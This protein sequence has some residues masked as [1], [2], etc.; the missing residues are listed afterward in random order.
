[1][2]R[3]PLLRDRSF[4]RQLLDTW[5]GNQLLAELGGL[6]TSADGR[7]TTPLLQPTLR[8]LLAQGKPVTAITLLRAL[9]EPSLSLQLDGLLTMFQHENLRE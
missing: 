2:L 7:S 3:A 8:Q 6:L 4:G 9:P 1:L 5:T